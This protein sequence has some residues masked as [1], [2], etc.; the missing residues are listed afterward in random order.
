[1][2]K[3]SRKA[4]QLSAYIITSAFFWFIR[5][6]SETEHIQNLVLGN[7]TRLT[8]SNDQL[9]C[10]PDYPLKIELLLK[11]MLAYLYFGGVCTRELIKYIYI[12]IYVH[13]SGINSEPIAS[14]SCSKICS[15]DIWVKILICPNRSRL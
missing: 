1:M 2:K 14:K 8:C 13:E 6:D 12:Y 11:F 15:R 4:V 9:R 5:I 10:D 3:Y 7:S